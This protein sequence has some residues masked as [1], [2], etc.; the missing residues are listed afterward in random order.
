MHVN[1]QTTAAGR[2]CL[3]H[4]PR[5]HYCF[6]IN[7]NINN[8]TLFRAF[9]SADGWL[10]AGAGKAEIKDMFHGPSLVSRRWW[11]PGYHETPCPVYYFWTQSGT[12]H[13]PTFEF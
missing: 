12:R 8:N 13:I 7:I 3:D 6:R 11:R 4:V 1:G 9:H 5:G 10:S 2:R